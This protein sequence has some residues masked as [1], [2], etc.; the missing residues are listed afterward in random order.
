MKVK[1]KKVLAAL[2]F[3]IILTSTSV[4]GYASIKY[5]LNKVI[6]QNVTVG[7]TVKYTDGLFVELVNYDNDTLTF[8]NIDETETQKHYLT[9]TYNYTILVDGLDIEVSS[10]SDDIIVDNLVS[11]ESTISITFSLNQEKEYNNGD[12]LNIQ[13]YFEGVEQTLG[14]FS[15]SNPININTASEADLYAIGLTEAEV[16]D[17]MLERSYA[18]FNSVEDWYGETYISDLVDRYQDYETSDIIIFD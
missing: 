1:M 16:N 15:I 10:L 12:T 6:D 13:F 18:P 4:F 17:T 3:G 8:F 2:L 5:V 9:Y 14:G 7:E 11:T